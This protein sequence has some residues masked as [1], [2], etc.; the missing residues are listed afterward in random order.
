M[1]DGNHQKVWFY[2]DCPEADRTTEETA[3]AT[4][5]ENDTG[6]QVR[7]QAN[8][9]ADQ[10]GDQNDDQAGEK[11]SVNVGDNVEDL[12][13]VCFEVT[14]TDAKDS[15]TR[16]PNKLLLHKG[17]TETGEQIFDN[18]NT[19]IT[20]VDVKPHVMPRITYSS[21]DGVSF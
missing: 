10:A 6:N 14:R 12:V 7:D 17:L 20:C 18:D 13:N 8:D 1:A 19:K 4:D 9:G 21:W 2:T 11:A 3:L 5:A 16:E 15:Q